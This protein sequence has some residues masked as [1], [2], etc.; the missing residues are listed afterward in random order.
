MKANIAIC[1]KIPPEQYSDEYKNTLI[2][3]SEL[4]SNNKFINIYLGV[5][6][7]NIN[8]V[9]YHGLSIINKNIYFIVDTIKTYGVL[10][11]EKYNFY[12]GFKLQRNYE[13]VLFL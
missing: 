3:I 8:Y 5:E 1:L 7:N 9:T 2:K 12:L 13:D 4:S 6:D 11:V 10:H